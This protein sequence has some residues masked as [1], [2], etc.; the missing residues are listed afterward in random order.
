MGKLIEVGIGDGFLLHS[1]K[2]AKP[3]VEIYGVDIS[4][5]R[6][7]YAHKTLKSYDA[8]CVV[9]DAAA[10]PFRD[11]VFDSLI[12][13]EVLEHIPDNNLAL[14]ETYRV[15]QS[16]NGNILITV[17]F[18]Q[19]LSQVMCPYCHKLFT[20]N[21]HIHSY[22]K[23]KIKQI[24]HEAGFN[25]VKILGFGSILSFNRFARTLP[26]GIRNAIDKIAYLLLGTAR[27]YICN[28]TKKT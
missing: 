7:I 21:G 5:R 18:R 20:V 23:E 9:A 6:V 25:V 15:L 27:Y 1:L 28:A 13:S 14:S 12:C 22:D 3:N 26:F 2:S 17:P 11:E 4:R 8:Y 16:A 19:R 24:M 10:L